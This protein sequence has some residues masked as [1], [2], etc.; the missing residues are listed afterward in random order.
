[1]DDWEN[2]RAVKALNDAIESNR[3]PHGILLHGPCLEG[4]ETVALSLSQR[5]L[6]TD[7]PALKHPDFHA[8]RPSNKMRQI[9]ADDTRELV[10]EVYKAPFVSSKK[11]AIV[12][13]ADRMNVTAANA[14][15]KTLEEPPADT[16]LFLLTTKPHSLLPTIR[17]RCFS[18]RLPLKEIPIQSEKWTQ[19]LTDYEI[20]IAS[21]QNAIQDP[22]ARCELIM[23]LYGLI[24]RLD[25]QL[26]AELT[27]QEEAKHEAAETLSEEEK[28]AFTTGIY[29]NIRQRLLT[30]IEITTRNYALK[31]EQDTEL[32]HKLAQVITELE[33]TSSL[34]EVNLNEATAL[35]SFFLASLRI[36]AS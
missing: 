1:M 34:L 32:P 4:L 16:T 28:I 13:D 35:E 9:S 21:A 25:H 17:S 12:Y 24:F 19:W 6:G 26:L 3:L 11:V 23:T 7:R 36:W 5:L 27:E 14:F 30:E 31:Q 15:L 18:F 33:K 8:L 10:H 2:F 22:E 20:W 29:K